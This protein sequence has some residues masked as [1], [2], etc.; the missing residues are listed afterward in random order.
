ME[1]ILSYFSVMCLM[2]GG[3]LAIAHLLSKYVIS[4]FPR[5]DIYYIFC[6][7]GI[8]ILAGF[9]SLKLEGEENFF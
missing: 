6:L 9:I 8:G 4:D 1:K 7:A 2:V 5:I 3:Y